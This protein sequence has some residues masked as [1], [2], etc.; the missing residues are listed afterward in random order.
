MKFSVVTPE[1]TK[2]NLT[3]LRELYDS[4]VA[5]TYTDWE[6]IVYCNG[7]TVDEIKPSFPEDERIV[8]SDEIREHERVYLNEKSIGDIKNAAASLATGTVIVE[9]DHDDKLHPDCLQELFNV[10]STEPGVGFVYTDALYMPE[11]GQVFYPFQE[12]MGWTHHYESWPGSDS[13]ETGVVTHSWPVNS[14]SVGMIWWAP[15][16]VR[17]WRRDIYDIVGGYDPNDWCCEDLGLLIRTYLSGMEMRHI[18]KALYYYRVTGDNNSLTVRNEK[19]QTTSMEK[20]RDNV[21]NLAL[22]E[23]NQRGLEAIEL[24]GGETTWPGFTNI[25][26]RHGDIKH[27]LNDGIPFPDNSVGVIR[28]WH[29]LEHLHDKQKIM[30]ECWRVLAHGGW[31][32]V[33]IP[34]TD[35]RGAFQDPTHVSYWN[36]NS[37]W[38]YY[39]QDKAQYLEPSPIRF[40]HYDTVDYDWGDNII[41]TRVA[42][43]ALKDP[44]GER[45]PGELLI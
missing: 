21:T 3:F 30:E 15:D 45:F 11:P 23:T 13:E 9:V 10:Y 33:E 27:D 35:G 24:G 18:P 20:F 40:Q 1:H 28:A 31:L 43:V 19:I 39:R 41:A 5:Q 34:S 38:Y 44:E 25:D 32:L 29:I 16:H 2:E 22:V 8:W 36:A 6:W 14:K 17:S 12:R 42:L 4:L 37:F 26:L 7:V